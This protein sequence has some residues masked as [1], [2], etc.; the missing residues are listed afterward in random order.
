MSAIP[1]TGTWRDD[2]KHLRVAFQLTLAPIFLW[3]YTVSGAALETRIVPAFI[4]LH[5]F[6]Y[7]GITAFNSY[8]DRDEGPVGG[9]ERPPPVRESLLPVAVGLKAAGLAMALW[10][11]PAFAAIYAAFV[12]LSVL[13][14]H[15]AIRWKANP[16]LSAA[17]VCLGQGG[18]GFLS[19]WAA[20][21]GGAATAW[22][23]RGVLGGAVA[24]L[25]TLGMYPVTQVYQ[26]E[27][28]ARRGD[29]TLCVALGPSGGLAISQASFALAGFAA[30]AV[31]VLYYSRLDAAILGGAYVALILL[32]GFLRARF[33]ALPRARAFRA[34][35]TLNFGAAAA[36]TIF[37]AARLARW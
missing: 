27:E 36:F 9:L 24:A 23:V 12:V 4:A 7:T 20:A 16:W 10:V 3:G 34:V 22:S 5:L 1:A 37:I 11:G 26:V 6:L 17:V 13:Y 18:L 33:G 25:T 32:V 28:D 29:R 8:Y 15:P 2:W 35:M 30:V 21:T 31:A 19:G 14:S